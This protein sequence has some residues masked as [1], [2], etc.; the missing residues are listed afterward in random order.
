MNK[1]LRSF[2][3]KLV[4]MIPVT[5]IGLLIHNPAVVSQDFSSY[6][7]YD[8]MTKKLKSLVNANKGIAAIESIGKTIEGRDLW[9][10]TIANPG[11]TPVDERPGMFIAFT[12]EIS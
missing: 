7:N 11:G 9:V 5:V 6:Q 1:I 2:K 3:R 8:E 12:K 10:V 4:I